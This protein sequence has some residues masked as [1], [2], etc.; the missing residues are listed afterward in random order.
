[1]S[2]DSPLPLKYWMLK[3]CVRHYENLSLVQFFIYWLPVHRRNIL[4]YKLMTQ[5]YPTFSYRGGEAGVSAQSSCWPHV[6]NLGGSKGGW[7]H[8]LV[9]SSGSS[10]NVSSSV[11]GGSGGGGMAGDGG[12]T[13]RTGPPL[14][15][16]LSTPDTPPCMLIAFRISFRSGCLVLFITSIGFPLNKKTTFQTKYH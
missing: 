7:F 5:T 10:E 15:N 1:M 9:W 14:L 13:G 2:I 3:L 8:D 4:K 16:P 6:G 11:G 12:V